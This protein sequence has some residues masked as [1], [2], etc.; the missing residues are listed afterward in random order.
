MMFSIVIPTFNRREIIHRAI[1]SALAQGADELEVIVVDDG[2]VDGTIESLAKIYSDRPVR[3]LR[4]NRAKGP[5]GARNTGMLAA[6]GE[7]IGLLDSDDEFLPGHLA[8]AAGAFR[9]H[10]ELDVIFGRARYERNG[11]PEDYMGPN[12][13]RK[14]AAAPKLHSDDSLTIFGT[15]FFTH[16]LQ[17][18]CWFNL[19]TVVLRPSAARELMNED[20]RVSED[21]EF[22]VRLS[23]IHQFACLHAPQIR[24]ALHNDNLS[25]ESAGSVPDH[26]P[27]LLRALQVI[28][29]Y[30]DLNAM[31]SRLI[32][33]QMAEVLFDW[34][35]RS[36]RRRQLLE[37]FRLH[38]A[39]LRH[40]RRRANLWAILKLPAT[41]LLR[42]NCVP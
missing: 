29:A 24:Y 8:A 14:L 16:L 1:D 19:S 15:E 17:Y 2:S 31:Q 37:A 27:R 11:Q 18:G 28:L 23:R 22:W 25:F 42:K 41:P 26:A 12:F 4:N 20:L 10:P 32:R 40:G 7:L 34:A 35:Y 39:S 9:T 21:Y 30:P 3:I 33:K 13:E 6:R 36:S 38:L 5:A